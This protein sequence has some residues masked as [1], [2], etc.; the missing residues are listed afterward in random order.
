MDRLRELPYMKAWAAK[1]KD[2]GLVLIGVH[3]P[4]FEFERA[5]PT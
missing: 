1:Y 5:W 3:A 2:V 4:E